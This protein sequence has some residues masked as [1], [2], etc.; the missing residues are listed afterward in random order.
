[1]Y[2]YDGED[3]FGDVLSTITGTSSAPLSI[4]STGPDIFINFVADDD[5]D[6]SGF[7]LQYSTG[8]KVNA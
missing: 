1:M 3:V 5:T 7:E 6:Q 4:S 8:K 2:V